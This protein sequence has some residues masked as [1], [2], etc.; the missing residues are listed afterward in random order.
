MSQILS[1]YSPSGGDCKRL[2]IRCHTNSPEVQSEKR[3][4][5]CFSEPQD[6]CLP[7]VA[8]NG[9]ADNNGPSEFTAPQYNYCTLTDLMKSTG[10][11]FKNNDDMDLA[12]YQLSSRGNKISPKDL[13]IEWIPVSGKID[14]SSQVYKNTS[15][16][17][18][19]NTIVADRSRNRF[20]LV[21]TEIDSCVD[22][23]LSPNARCRDNTEKHSSYVKKMIERALEELST[24]EDKERLIEDIM[25]FLESS[26]QNLIGRKT[27]PLEVSQF[28]RFQTQRHCSLASSAHATS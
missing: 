23:V 17:N 2:K 18:N 21:D 6:N 1:C 7:S 19:N 14:G 15:G 13:T 27:N 11:S 8:F 9:L 16:T 25:L 10:S 20:Q 4:L 5:D 12:K 26:Q 22:T 28:Y 3:R 24:A